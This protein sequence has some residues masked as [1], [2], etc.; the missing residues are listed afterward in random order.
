VKPEPPDDVIGTGGKLGYY[1][2][3]VGMESDLVGLPYGVRGTAVPL[4]FELDPEAAIRAQAFAD[5]WYR[6]DIR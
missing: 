1:R 5:P 3:S 4:L 2:G 6:N